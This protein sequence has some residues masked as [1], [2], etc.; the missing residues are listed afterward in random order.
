MKRVIQKARPN[1][2]LKA[3]RRSIAFRKAEGEYF[4]PA[5]GEAAT[6]MRRATN[7]RIAAER[8]AQAESAFA[9][10]RLEFGEARKL[11]ADLPKVLEFRKEFEGGR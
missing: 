4:P 8:E 3:R 2:K 10:H 11:F 1:G 5:S 9:G 6:I 7:A